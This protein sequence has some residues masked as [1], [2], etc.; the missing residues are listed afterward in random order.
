MSEIGGPLAQIN[1]AGVY[2]IR[3][4]GG[5]PTRTGEKTKSHMILRSGNLDKIPVSAQEQLLAYG[6]KTILDIRDE[7]EATHY[8]NV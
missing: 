3:D 4:L 6:V 8:P 2:N 5:L 7:W 1:I